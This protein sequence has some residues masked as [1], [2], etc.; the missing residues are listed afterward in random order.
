MYIFNIQ[1]GPRKTGLSLEVCNSRI[2]PYVD[3]ERRSI[4]QTA[5]CFIQ[6]KTGVLHITILKYSLRSFNVTKLC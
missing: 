3:I 5:Q 6:S 2:G 4:Y 1:G